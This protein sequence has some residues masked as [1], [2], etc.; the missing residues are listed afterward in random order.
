[1]STQTTSRHPVT[2]PPRAG[3]RAD[4][5]SRAVAVILEDGTIHALGAH[6]KSRSSE[7]KHGWSTGSLSGQGWMLWWERRELD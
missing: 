1:M 2:N 7:G 3:H 5:R 6:H 4:S